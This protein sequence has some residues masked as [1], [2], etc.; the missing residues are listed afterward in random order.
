MF[1]LLI[2]GLRSNSF[3]NFCAPILWFTVP[4]N[5]KVCDPVFADNEP[6]SI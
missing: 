6:N 5:E 3:S 4:I 2:F 1:E